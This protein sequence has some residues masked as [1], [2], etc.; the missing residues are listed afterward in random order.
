MLVE[1]QDGRCRECSGQLEIVGADDVAL[2][3]ECC[4]CGDTYA[5]ETDA[6]GDGAIHYW[7]AFMAEKLDHGGDP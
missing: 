2:T 4:E 6:F 1:P 5:V 3:V 7:P